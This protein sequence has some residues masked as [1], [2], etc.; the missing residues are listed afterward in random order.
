MS[1]GDNN[2]KRNALLYKKDKKK[3]CE[4]ICENRDPVDKQEM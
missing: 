2:V 3:K 1:G 4:K